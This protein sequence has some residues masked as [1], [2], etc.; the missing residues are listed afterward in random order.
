MSNLKDEMAKAPRYTQEEIAKAKAKNARD[1][2]AA[3]ALEKADDDMVYADLYANH[4]KG[5]NDYK[6]NQD[7]VLAE[8]LEE[9]Q[10]LKAFDEEIVRYHTDI[11]NPDDLF[12]YNNL[13]EITKRTR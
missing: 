6:S 1:K 3:E 2:L 7:K 10:E 8:Q 4:P 13:E 5:G 11:D 9:E 12:H